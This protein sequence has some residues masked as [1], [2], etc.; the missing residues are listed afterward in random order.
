MT[1]TGLYNA[2]LCRIKPTRPF[3][4]RLQF[5]RDALF[6]PENLA[7]DRTG[8]G[9]SYPAKVAWAQSSVGLV[10]VEPSHSEVIG[11]RWKRVRVLLPT[12][13]PTSKRKGVEVIEVAE[14]NESTGPHW[15]ATLNT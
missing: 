2:G 9:S 4:P 10:E 6:E 11:E 13:S 3:V 1:R 8:A 7:I 12:R 14:S 15:C 5:G